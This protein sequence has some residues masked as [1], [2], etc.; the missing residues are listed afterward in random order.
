[1][2]IPF[3]PRWKRTWSCLDEAQLA[4][5]ADGSL[6]AAQRT[7]AEHHLSKCLRCRDNV[8]VLL[9]SERTTANAVP[10][11][12]IARV[13]HLGDP[14]GAQGGLRWA[15]AGALACLLMAAIGITLAHR[16]QLPDTVAV[17]RPPAAP[18]VATGPTPA[19][20]HDE[21]RKLA[22]PATGPV[23]IAPADGASVARDLEVR[24]QP[25]ASAVS[26]E[27]RVLDA[28]GDTVWHTQTSADHLQ[29][30]ADASLHGGRKY[31]VLLSA[32][33]ATGKT[34]HARAV[35]FNV[36]TGQENR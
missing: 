26:Y 25:L 20:E 23:V 34:V 16:P 15:W 14:R 24:W 27:V 30:P 31:F 18:P 28:D 3:P 5:Y 7:R 19:A 17:S 10:P 36:E 33:L 8:A 9:R 1:M 21:V 2:R 6:P 12:W 32:S 4:A 11:A 35:S 13:L 29:I 22:Q